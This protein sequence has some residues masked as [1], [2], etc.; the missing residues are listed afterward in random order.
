MRKA[1]VF[2]AV[3]ALAV[4]ACGQAEPDIVGTTGSEAAEAEAADQSLADTAANGTLPDLPALEISVPKL[5]YV[6]D[7]AF[8][9]P[10]NEIG[11]LQRSHAD[12]C[13][14]QG[15]TTCQ[16]VGMS[17][18]GEEAEAVSGELELAVAS[19]HARAFGTLL[20]NEAENGGA[21]QISAEITAEELSKQIV[22]TE[23]HLRARVQLRD[24]LE[25]VLRTR[26]G[27]VRELV[28]AER[29]VAQ[30]NQEIDQARSWLKEMRGRVAYSRMTVRYE[31]G[32]NAGGE[33]LRPI[34]GVLGSLGSIL[35]FVIA[36]M[37]ALAAVAAPVLAVVRAG[38]WANRRFGSF[39][40]DAAG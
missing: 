30:V 8:R 6:Y 9:L 11:K 37:I 5:A 40:E 14:Q 22:D 17:K 7:F 24:R 26:R 20:E 38:R 21:E 10:G 13:E 18:T 15:P 39:A 4:S 23:A 29:S 2:C 19:N 1:Y 34:V 12:L 36:A 3:S 27:D 25:E 28:E 31:T 32:E 35:G 16:I 33:F